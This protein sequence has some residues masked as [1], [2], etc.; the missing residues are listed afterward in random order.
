MRARISIRSLAA[1]ATFAASGLLTV[2]PAAAA[3]GDYCL[4]AS[5]EVYCG[6]EEFIYENDIRLP[7]CVFR[8]EQAQWDCPWE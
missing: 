7:N 5:G 6:T 4:Y 2:S 1:A 8:W 3:P